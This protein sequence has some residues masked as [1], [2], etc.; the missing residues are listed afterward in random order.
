M[1]NTKSQS[2][3]KYYKAFLEY[4]DLPAEDESTMT[5]G[6]LKSSFPTGGYG[7][8]VA[9]FDKGWSSDKE[10]IPV[11]WQTPYSI[12]TRDDY[13]RCICDHFGDKEKSCPQQHKDD[14]D[15]EDEKEEEEKE[16]EKEEEEEKDDEKEDEKD[17]ELTLPEV[18]DPTV[19]FKEIWDRPH[20]N[21]NEP[22]RTMFQVDRSLDYIE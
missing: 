4:F 21:D 6:N 7:D 19:E 2:R 9:Y 20:F 5:C 18:S 1:G 14:D 15:K 10:C 8:A 17:D 16:E 12:Y 11:K 13:K 22:S 3:I